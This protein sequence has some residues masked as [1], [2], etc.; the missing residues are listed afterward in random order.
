MLSRRAIRRVREC[1]RA[2]NIDGAKHDCRLIDTTTIVLGSA[3]IVPVRRDRY[4]SRT[5]SLG[6]ISNLRCAGTKLLELDITLVA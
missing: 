5:L 2:L 3:P 4:Q 6:I 1:W